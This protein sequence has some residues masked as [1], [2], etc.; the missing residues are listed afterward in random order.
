MK[1]ILVPID[2]STVAENALNYAIEIAAKFESELVLYH[3]Y[4]FN[5]KF[6]YDW[7]FTED[8]QPYVRNLEQK[9]SA[10]VNKFK[11]KFIRNGL[12]IQTRV[13]ELHVFTLF[14]RIV[15]KH[16]I[17]MII[18]GS[19][20][21]SGLEKVI[22]GSVA[23]GTL[24]LAKV[25][26]LVVPPNQSYQPL[27]QVI[28]AIDLDH[29]STNALS[30]LQKLATK[31][32]T[33]VTIL[34]I[35]TGGSNKDAHHRV[36]SFL[37]N[38]ETTYHEAPMSKSINQSINEFI[39]INKYDLMCMIRR[40]KGFFESLFQRSITEEQVYNTSIPLLVLPEV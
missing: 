10:T 38:V 12:L 32:G 28:L 21:A 22:F 20:G 19:K 17:D 1:K 24:D 37:K 30:P 2:F 34:S 5:K 39:K 6:D 35:N 13:E 25:P 11:E 15:K 33:K 4:T 3:A 14:D 29:V 7:N 31:F 9:M 8:E 36:E 27:E 23:S 18:M 26:V 40:E 16:E